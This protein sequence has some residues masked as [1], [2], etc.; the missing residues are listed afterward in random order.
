MRSS[1]RNASSGNKIVVVIVKVAEK[2]PE[3]TEAIEEFACSIVYDK[4]VVS[5]AGTVAI[6]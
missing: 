3:V 1:V 2:E 4:Y 6:V 5:E